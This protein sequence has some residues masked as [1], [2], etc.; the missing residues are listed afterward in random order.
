[1]KPF[2]PIY[3]L[4]IVSVSCGASGASACW[5]SKMR[6][7]QTLP[8]RL[9][10]LSWWVNPDLL[11]HQVQRVRRV[12]EASKVGL[13]DKVSKGYKVSGRDHQDNRVLLALLGS[14][15]S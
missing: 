7:A 14:D 1:M 6:S 4:S 12:N 3:V 5:S 13:V 15:G 9:R 10:R 8:P 2:T 11:D